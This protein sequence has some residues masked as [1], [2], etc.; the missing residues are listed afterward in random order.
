VS[1]RNGGGSRT[2]GPTLPVKWSKEQGVS[3]QKELPGYGQST[4]VIWK[5]VV[6]VT[7]VEGPH[8]ER[9]LVLAMEA[10]TGQPLWRHEFPASTGLPSNYMAARAAP[11]PAVDANGVYVFFE[12]GDLAAITHNGKELWRRSLTTEYGAFQN[13]HG[14]GSSVA[15][16]DDSLYVHIQHSGP[17][18]LLCVDK[19][20]GTNRWKADRKSSMSWSTPVVMDDGGRRMVVVSSGGEVEAFDARM[21][22]VCWRAGEFAGNATPSPTIDG[23]DL[24][25]GAALSDFESAN[26]VSKSN[27]CL[28]WQDGKFSV[29]WR[30]QR[31]MCDYASPVVCGSYVYYVNRLGVVYCLNR[32]D[33]AEL[34]SH[35]LPGPC[36]ATP[37]VSGDRVFFFGKD[38]VTT[39]IEAASEWREVARNSLWDVENPPKPE[40]YVETQGGPHGAERAG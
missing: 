37:V 10:K 8:K 6:Y 1:F 30:A 4:P 35:R 13:H 11:T 16:D 15:Q 29:R 26:N 28:T 7:A 36:W 25:L 33:G 17:S 22:T 27:A 12:G 24:L 21:G 14:L 34:Y 2:S 19:K 18:Y 31:A 39:V 38:G 23:N 32:A 40:S 3:W 5:G 20:T 9:C